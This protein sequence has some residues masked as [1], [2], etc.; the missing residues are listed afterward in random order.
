MNTYALTLPRA[1]RAVSLGTFRFQ[2]FR[3]FPSRLK[4]A[5]VLG[6]LA[7]WSGWAQQPDTTPPVSQ[8][9][10]IRLEQPGLVGLELRASASGSFAIEMSEDLAVWTPVSTN[11]VLSA[12]NSATVTIQSAGER[13]FFR[14]RWTG[15][16]GLE[17]GTNLASQVQVPFRYTVTGSAMESWTEQETERRAYQSL[18]PGQND[19]WGL[20]MAMRDETVTFKVKATVRGTSATLR[21]WEIGSFGAR[22]QVANLSCQVGE[23][24]WSAE[25]SQQVSLRQFKSYEWQL[26]VVGTSTL[27]NGVAEM[28]GYRQIPRSARVA[29]T[30]FSRDATI[31]RTESPKDLGT[32]S[33]RFTPTHGGTIAGKSFQVTSSNPDVAVKFSDTQSTTTGS[34]GAHVIATTTRGCGDCNQNGIDDCVEIANGSVTDCN[35]NGIP[36]GCEPPVP[37]VI[38]VDLRNTACQNGWEAFPFNTV[39][40]ANAVAATGN[41]LRIRAGSYTERLLLSKPLRLESQGGAAR[42][43]PD[44]CN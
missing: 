15:V 4:C 44:A 16:A 33:V 21:V 5:I 39:A 31:T 9:R 3:E 22:T 34:E 2:A 6:F 29:G 20:P 10:L 32:F 25:N 40:K 17:T 26:A 37:G 27:G 35:G 28:T 43:G 19:T 14:S 7:V 42:I 41:T 24:D 38:W 8:M 36:D 30:S 12:S 11:T 23:W 1:G 13:L 18:S